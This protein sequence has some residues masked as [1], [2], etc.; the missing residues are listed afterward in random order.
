MHQEKSMAKIL[1]VE[2]DTS[3]ATLIEEW[4]TGEHHSLEIMYDGTSGWDRLLLCEYDLIILD[5]NLPYISG[6][7][8]C[9]RYRANQ[10]LAPIIMLTGRSAIS[11]KEEGLDSG[12]DDYLTKP[13][14]MKELSARVRALLRR[15]RAL[16][17][18]LLTVGDITLDPAKYRVTKSGKD[19]HL[20]PKDFALLEFFMRHP[21]DVFSTESLLQ[22]V[23]SSE[24]ESTGEALR[25][26]VKRLRQKLDGENVDLEKSFIENIPRIG[27]RLR[28]I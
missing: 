9:K 26:S 19:V 2:D 16:V 6:V 23:W 11:E 20:V 15:P 13:F 3:L 22:R 7:D 10:G 24:S 17:S 5:W 1:L 18:N 25:S 14:N 8:L 27:Y 21:E 12:A 4:L 28:K